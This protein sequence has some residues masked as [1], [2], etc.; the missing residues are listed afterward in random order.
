MDLRCHLFSDVVPSKGVTP[1]KIGRGRA[2][3]LPKRLGA[4]SIEEW[5][6]GA[7][8]WMLV[9]ANGN[10]AEAL[11]RRPQLDREATLELATRLFP[12]DNLEPIGD[13]DLSDTCP[14][15]D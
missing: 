3:S 5:I 2:R 12:K 14:A 11:H 15:D 7:K 9:Y 1:R 4:T 10:V 13:G 6:V 8:T